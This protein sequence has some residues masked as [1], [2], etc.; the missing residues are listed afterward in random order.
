MPWDIFD[1]SIAAN[2]LTDLAVGRI[3]RSGV[4]ITRFGVYIADAA[5]AFQVNFFM[6]RELVVGPNG[7]KNGIQWAA[8]NDDKTLT[9]IARQNLP[10]E[11]NVCNVIATAGPQTATV[12]VEYE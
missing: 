12:V 9:Q 3:W 1:I 2:V 10:G 11:T 4:A 8:G 6:G 7:R 5:T